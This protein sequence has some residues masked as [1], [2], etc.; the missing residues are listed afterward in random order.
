MIRLLRL[1]LVCAD[2]GGVAGLELVDSGQTNLHV[3][4]GHSSVLAS[5]PWLDEQ[6]E[7]LI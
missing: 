4:L 2:R 6:L 5:F 7:F 3:Q 1:V